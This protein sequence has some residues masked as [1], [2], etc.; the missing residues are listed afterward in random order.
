MDQRRRNHQ[1]SHRRS[2]CWVLRRLRFCRRLHRLGEFQGHHPLRQ[3]QGC[4]LLQD[5]QG[6][7]RLLGPPAAIA[8]ENPRTVTV[9]KTAAGF[10][11][12]WAISV[13]ISIG[14]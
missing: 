10:N 6:R 11:S 3:L 1:Y 9:A 7:H 12:S 2:S 5:S 13:A 14:E 8:Y 4:H